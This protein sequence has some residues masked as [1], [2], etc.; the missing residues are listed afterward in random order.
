MKKNILLLLLPIVIFAQSC[1]VHHP[2]NSHHGNNSHGNRHGGH[3]TVIPSV[4]IHGGHYGGHGGNLLGAL[5]IGG[6]IGHIITE[7]AHEKHHEK[8]ATTIGE[9]PSEESN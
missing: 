7:V 5:I 1:A 8:E 2:L 6:I 9:Q 4:L 3:V